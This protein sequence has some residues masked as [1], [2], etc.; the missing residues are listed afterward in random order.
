MCCVDQCISWVCYC[1]NKK[2]DW[3]LS[4]MHH[5]DPN[6][7]LEYPG[8]DKNIS[9]GNVLLHQGRRGTQDHGSR[10]R[11][12][13]PINWSKSETSN[14]YSLLILNFYWSNFGCRCKANSMV[15]IVFR[16]EQIIR[17]NNHISLIRQKIPWPNPNWTQSQWLH[18]G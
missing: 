11:M 5:A 16:G 10:D 14:W 15:L 4:S 13:S 2:C 17:V 6:S 9:E 3:W 12:W 7:M 18:W 8:K 1:E